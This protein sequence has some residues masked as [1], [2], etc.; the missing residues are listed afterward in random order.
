MNRRSFLKQIGMI[1]GIGVTGPALVLAGTQKKTT[2]KLNWV[3]QI[4]WREFGVDSSYSYLSEDEFRCAR[5]RINKPIE[6]VP[7]NP[8]SLTI[9]VTTTPNQNMDSDVKI[10]W[11]RIVGPKEIPKLL[12]KK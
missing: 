12:E 5:W 11:I 6:S 2:L 3:Q 1:C 9:Q 4:V 10:G 8:K 7:T